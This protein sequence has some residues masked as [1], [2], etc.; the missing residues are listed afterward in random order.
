LQH[1]AAA[2][3]SRRSPRRRSF[4]EDGDCLRLLKIADLSAYPR[5]GTNY[6]EGNLRG[7]LR[8]AT[9]GGAGAARP[10]RGDG[11]HSHRHREGSLGA[12]AQAATSNGGAKSH[13][14]ARRASTQSRALIRSTLGRNDGPH[15]KFEWRPARWHGSRPRR[16]ISCARPTVRGRAADGRRR[17]AVRSLFS[18]GAQARRSERPVISLAV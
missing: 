9:G 7:L 5:D 15:A 11:G 17:H 2:W 13:G 6:C 10:R 1:I 3:K 14:V 12:G 18:K 8:S 4:P 16:S